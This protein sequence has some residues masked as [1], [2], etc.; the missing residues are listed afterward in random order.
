MTDLQKHLLMLLKEIDSI[1]RENEIEYYLAAGTALG[2]ARHQGFIPWDDDAD[3][4]MTDENWRKFYSVRNRIPA[5]RKVISVEE[6]FSAGYTVNRYVDLTTTRLYRYL[7]ASPQDAGIIVDILVLDPVPDDPRKIREHIV[8]LTDYTNILTIAQM[9]TQQC[10]Y[11]LHYEENVRACKKEGREAVLEKLRQ[12]TV[13]KYRDTSGG[14]LVQRDAVAPHVWKEELF[15]RPR[16][17]PFEDTELPVAEKLYEQ[18]CDAFDEDWMYIP[19]GAGRTLHRKGYNLNIS[20]NNAYEDYLSWSIRRKSRSFTGSGCITEIWLV[21]FTG[22]RP[23]RASRSRKRR[24]FI[25][26]IS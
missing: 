18:L 3:I 1:C 13:E 2:A 11:P 6:D 4:Y 8:D 15:G 17:V 21:C 26:I 20:N 25:T 12:R 22:T 5:G 19:K 7:C 9:Y 23:K 24:W 16:Y 10:P 14:V